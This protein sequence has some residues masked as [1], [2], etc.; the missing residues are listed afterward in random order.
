MGIVAPADSRIEEAIPSRYF[1]EYVSLTFEH[2]NA[3]GIKAYNEYLTASYG[4]YMQLP[5]V[6]LRVSH[7]IY[8]AYWK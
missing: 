3:M 1:D 2:L 6:E 4:D 7:H 8:T 5:P